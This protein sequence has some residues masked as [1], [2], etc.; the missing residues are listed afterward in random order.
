MKRF[1]TSKQRRLLKEESGVI[2]IVSKPTPGGTSDSARAMPETDEDF[3]INY[4]ETEPD[5]GA[6]S[7]DTAPE[8]ELESGDSDLND[9]FVDPYAKHL[10][11]DDSS[12]NAET[13]LKVERIGAGLKKMMAASRELENAMAILKSERS[14]YTRGKALIDIR[15]QLTDIITQI[16][17]ELINLA[18]HDASVAGRVRDILNH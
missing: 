12:E 15:I 5:Q 16:K 1:S 3:D 11:P 13:Q 8:P 14:D 7:L 18:D 10:E 17:T 9:D 6:I 2:P 4:G